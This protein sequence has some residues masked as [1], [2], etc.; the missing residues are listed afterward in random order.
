MSQRI[1]KRV[2]LIGWDAADWQFIDPLLEEG[3]MPN[4]QK[5]ID[6]GVMG[7]IA[8]L[9]PMLSPLLWNSIA[10]GKLADKHDILGFTEP[11]GRGNIRPVTSTSRKAKALW[12]ILSPHGMRSCVVSWFASHPA[13]RI[14][15]AILT[16]HFAKTINEHGIE[17]PLGP[18]AVHPPEL[19]DTA[20][21]LRVRPVDLDP[22]Q[23]LP[24]IPRLYEIPESRHKG[25][26]AVA[27][28]LAEAAT[29][30]NGA[31]YFAERES[32]DLLAV[33]YG[34]IDQMGHGFMEF[35]PP[36]LPHVSDENFEWYSGVM[37]AT[38]Q[39]HD[40][41]LGRLMELA[42]EDTTIVLL[43]DHGFHSAA[44][45]PKI[46]PDPDDP[47]IHRGPGIDPMAWHRP[48]GVLVISG[49]PIKKDELVHGASLLDVAPTVL[50]MLGLPVA[51]DMDGR[52]LTHV[53]AEPREP[54]RIPTYEGE[55]PNDGVHRGEEAEDP[56]AAQQSLQHL[57][58]LGY[59]EQPSDNGAENVRNV[60]IERKAVLSQVYYSSARPE[61]ALRLMQEL[62]KE[63]DN[64]YVRSRIAMCLIDLNRHDEAEEVLKGIDDANAELP[65]VQT[66]W[67]QAKFARASYEQAFQ[68][69]DKALAA[70]P[71]VPDLHVYLGMIHIRRERYEMAEQAFRKA[72]E[73]DED[74]AAAHD[75]L[76][77]ALYMQKRFEDAVYQHM[78]S[79]ALVHHRPMTHIHL[80]QALAQLNQIDWSIRAFEVAAEL[81]PDLPYPHRCLAMLYRRAKGDMS[82][83][84]KHQVI[85]QQLRA[86]MDRHA[87]E[88]TAGAASEGPK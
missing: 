88:P 23:M 52:A 10:T 87:A 53:F 48:H 63:R 5:L 50:T 44:Q 1:A 69:F 59:I 62:R 79:A 71:R 30:H 68:H 58:D 83:A 57:V 13:E 37:G 66:L 3:L 42:G 65:I 51:D 77:V 26:Q 33:Y 17:I 80:G 78:R 40:M 18:L 56:Y 55:D 24:F 75:G 45:R 29:V 39:F 32:W 46:Y 15:G 19:F 49:P 54:A 12:N 41:M 70:D 72:L 67:G 25:V 61:Q 64:V 14:N 43:S 60:M 16:D 27:K 35:H 4:L 28:V 47:N 84:R 31:T 11:N 74:H 85:A 22:M 81:A 6:N 34:A 2:L 20:Q 9:S 21:Q 82:S 36:R 73:L 7:K 38:Y 8:T 76:G 86:K